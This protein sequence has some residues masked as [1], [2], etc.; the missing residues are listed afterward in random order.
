MT[1]DMSWDARP[2]TVP[3]R[4]GR[5]GRRFDFAQWYPKVVVY[6]RLRLGGASPLSG[7]RVLRRVGHLPRRSRRSRRRGHGRHRCAGL[8]R[9]R[10]GAGQQTSEAARRVSARLLRREHAAG[11]C[12][13]RGGR[14]K[15]ED[16]LVRREG[17]PLRDVAEPGLSLRG[18]AFRQRRRPR[19]L[20][21]RRREGLGRRRRGRAH[22]GRAGLAGPALRAVRL[23][24]DHQRAPDRRR[25]HRVPHDDP[26]RLRRPGT[27]RPR[28]RPQLYDGSA[29]EQRVARGM[30]RRGLHELSDDAGSGR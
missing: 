27:H 21:A 4:Q 11:R 15:K 13:R 3:R 8:R 29:R 6:D 10:V 5:Q 17:A 20:P 19:P 23:A 22:A 18:R 26:R 2:S 25:R 14:G 28:A 9:S 7:G 12:L 30:A 24:A 1:I 16:P